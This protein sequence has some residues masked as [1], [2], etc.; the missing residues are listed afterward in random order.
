MSDFLTTILSH[1]K[2][3]RYVLFDIQRMSMDHTT[4]SGFD[5]WGVI[6]FP[7]F[8]SDP[9]IQGLNCK[10][11]GDYV[12]SNF[13]ICDEIIC[14]CPKLTCE[15]CNNKFV[16]DAGDDIVQCEGCRGDVCLACEDSKL[17]C[18]YCGDMYC[19]LC[20]MENAFI[21]CEDCMKYLCKTCEDEKCGCSALTNDDFVPCLE[22]DT[23]S[24]EEDTG[25]LYIISPS[26]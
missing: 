7:L 1:N 24:D 10:T 4:I 11:C 25:E 22:G 15:L 9:Q 18:Y 8:G 20:F 13:D 19:G 14:K 3:Y 16:R 5:S 17:R 21:E 2:C 26:A 12:I 23:E 6:F